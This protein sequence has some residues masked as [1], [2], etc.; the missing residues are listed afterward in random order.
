MFNNKLVLAEIG[1]GPVGMAYGAL[2]W[3]RP[4]I[5]VMMFEPHPVYYK[6]LVEAA[7][8]RDNVQ[9]FNVAIGDFNGVTSFYDEGTS[10]FIDGVASPTAQH[11]GQIERNQY[12]VKVATLDKFD[13]GQ[14]DIL[15]ADTEG[16]EWFALKHMISRPREIVLE[17]YNGVATYINPYLFEIEE[18]ANKN[19]YKKKSISRGDFTYIK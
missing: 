13:V 19:G 9:I 11:K 10:S 14:I 16:A 6:Q 5:H 4:D 1:V 18:W 7:G 2:F 8:K 12:E 17:M 3:D 15:R